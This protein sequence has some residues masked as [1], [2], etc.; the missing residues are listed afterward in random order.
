MPQ[1]DSGIYRLLQFPMVYSAIQ[2]LI[3][4]GDGRAIVVRDFIRPQPGENVLDI[5]CGPATMLNYLDGVIY[6]G[7]DFNE[8]YIGEAKARF[9]DRGKFHVQSVDDLALE[10]GQ[11]FDTVLAIALLH[12]L[13][14]EQSHSLFAGAR[15]CLRKGG[16]LITLDCAWTTPQNPI[17]KLLIKMDRGRNIRTREGYEKLARA[18]FPAVD[19]VVRT[20]LNRFPYTHCIMTCQC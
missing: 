19:S 2:K 5:G 9:G 17:A 15:K 7:I 4:G 3:G 18:V 10:S 13:S 16:K 6:T 1:R 20:D 14:D 8:A 11:V 12:H